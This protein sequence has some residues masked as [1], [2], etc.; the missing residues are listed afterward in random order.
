MCYRKFVTKWYTP[1]EKSKEKISGVDW[2]A[3]RRISQI[4]SKYQDVE[5]RRFSIESR[6]RE[7]EIER[8]KHLFCLFFSMWSCCSCCVFL[9]LDSGYLFYTSK[10][11]LLITSNDW[12]I[13]MGWTSQ[14]KGKRQQ[15]PYPTY[16]KRVYTNICMM[17]LYLKKKKLFQQCA[18]VAN[19]VI[20]V[21]PAT[22]SNPKAQ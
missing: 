5:T 19:L 3:L 22:K 13:F 10:D 4:S 16:K 12:W 8:E 9:S 2:S 7:V 17:L 21:F 14:K 1:I 6:V 15:R 11:S 18:A 20:L